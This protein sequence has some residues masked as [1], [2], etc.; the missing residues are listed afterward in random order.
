LEKSDPT[1]TAVSSSQPWREDSKP[2]RRAPGLKFLGKNPAGDLVFLN[3]AGPSWAALTPGAAGLLSRC[4]GA[5]TMADLAGSS[6]DGTVVPRLLG[7]FER[8]GLLQ[9]QAPEALPAP[10]LIPLRYAALYL[11]RACNLACKFCFFSAGKAYKDE[12]TTG[13]YYRLLDDLSAMGVGS[14]YLMGG[15]P[16]MR[17]DVFDIASRARSLGMKAALVT[18]GTLLTEARAD[19]VLENFTFVQVSVDGLQDEHDRFRGPGTF[20]RTV[21]GIE[22]ILRRG[23]DVRVASVISSHNID[24]IEPFFE[25]LVGLGLTRVHFIN[26]QDCGRGRTSPYPTVSLRRFFGTLLPVWQK[27]RQYVEASHAL[28]FLWPVRGHRKIQCGAGNGMVEID[29]RGEVFA[30][31]KYMETGDTAGN[32]RQEGIAA[33]YQ[34]AQVLAD[35]R[36]ATV[37]THP[38]CSRCD[39]RFLCGGDCLAVDRP[40]GEAG[41]ACE[42]HGLFRWILTEVEAPA[43]K[44]QDLPGAPAGR[45]H[46]SRKE[47][48]P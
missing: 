37:L 8:L 13:D 2:P 32:V 43:I 1:L 45:T 31:Y 47:M 22:T 9:G 33:I 41:E 11:T 3:P 26:L 7:A 27:W 28:D 15:E 16:L 17:R 4:D 14:V 23:G 42:L 38:V 25:Y 24:N 19:K 6:A 39:F 48:N 35:I 12:M 34:D 30:C 36:G 10:E 44:D 29:P 40:K 21:R 18:N 46:L 5:H 20:E